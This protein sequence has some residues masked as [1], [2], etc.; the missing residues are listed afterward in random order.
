LS[1]RP[2]LA[3]RLALFL[4]AGQIVCFVGVIVVSHLVEVIGDPASTAPAWNV[5]AE[6]RVRT[7]VIASLAKRADG[8]VVIEP[9]PAL[10]VLAQKTPTLQYAVFDPATGAPVP[11][12]SPELASALSGHGD[13]LT[14]EMALFRIRGFLRREL[15]GSYHAASTPFGVFLIATHGYIFEWF[16]LFYH[17]YRD[18]L[19]MLDTYAL[20]ISIAAGIGWLTLWRGLAPLD[21]VVRQ[22]RKIDMGSLDQRIRHGAIPREIEPLVETINE[23][24]ERLDAGV[25]RQR[26]FL[27]N[28]AHELRTPLTIMQARI[29]SPEKPSFK[30][31]LAR[32]V[33]RLRNIVQQLLVYARFGKGEGAALRDDLDLVELT[34]A[35]VDDHAL[36]AVR[37]G[38]SVEFQCDSERELITGDRRALE[39]VV[40]NLIDNALRAEPRDGAVIVRVGPG[41]VIEVVDHGEGVEDDDRERIFEPFW[42]KSETTPGAGLGLAIAREIVEA[43]GG[44]IIVAPTPGG[45]ATFRL[46]LAPRRE[47][48]VR[49]S[50]GWR[51]SR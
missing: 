8:A 48:S 28:A 11:G 39:S 3:L 9:T 27:A 26:R 7:L 20:A 49:G 5:L 12:S 19:G 41:A 37:N 38:R 4:L 29:E 35:L 13:I 44:R 17:L 10:G 6:I 23:A 50:I 51:Q 32:D 47:Q 30:Q 16:D 40:G 25:A 21:G 14:Q 36:I 34:Q 2:S 22:A 45:G 42:R 43:H 1:R 33:R 24:L 18:I 31:D 46:A 15:S